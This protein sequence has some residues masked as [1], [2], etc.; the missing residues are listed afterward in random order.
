MSM[1]RCRG[2]ASPLERPPILNEFSMVVATVNGSGSQTSNMAI[3]RSLFPWAFPVC[4]EP[5]PF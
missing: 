5:V 3:L 1:P 4:D 2:G